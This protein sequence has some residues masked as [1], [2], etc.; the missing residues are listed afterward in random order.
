[1]AR[2]DG[3]VKP[4]GAAAAAAPT[5]HQCATTNATVSWLTPTLWVPF[6]TIV[7]V[8]PPDGAVRVRAGRSIQ[9]PRTKISGLVCAARRRGSRQQAYPCEEPAALA[10]VGRSGP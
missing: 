9:S 5:L 6:K 1:M 4:T 8:S 10:S 3:G 7:W 2:P